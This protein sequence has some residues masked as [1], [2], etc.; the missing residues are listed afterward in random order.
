M[1]THLA[2]W[3]K[4]T[5]DGIEAESILRACVH[6][7]FCN[8]TCPTYQLLGDELDGPRGRIY[9]IKQV[10][11]GH[12]PGE[13]TQLHLDRCL[14]CMNCET[15]CPSGVRYGRLVDI[16]RT[17]VE[18]RVRRPAGKRWQR[19]LLRTAL[20]TRWLFTSAVRLGR[21]VRP[22]LPSVLRNKLPLARTAGVVPRRS[23]A[24][25]VLLLNGCV[26]PA[27]MPAIDAA[28][29]RVL[30]ALG[31]E[32]IVAERS[33]CCGAIDYHLAALAAAQTSAR[34]NI[35]AWWPHIERGAEAIV[36]N[37][38]G[39]GAMV[40]EYAH[41]LRDDPVYAGKAGRVVSLTLDL[42]EFLAPMQQALA[43][44]GSGA[45][46][47]IAAPG[48]VAFHPPCTLQH[49]QKIRGTVEAILTALG[50]EL[51]PVADAHL[52][53][54]SAGSYSL[55]QS[56]L[57]LQLR[58]LKLENLQRER[59]AM[60]LSAN[61]GCIAHLDSG[62]EVPVRHWIEWVDRRLDQAEIG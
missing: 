4:S 52:C 22:L 50:A 44:K 17:I 2:D 8:A 48:R 12:R 41:V 45:V 36:I 53:C 11:E 47:A 5:A 20:T 10:L 26:Q 35:D 42:A 3:I 29:I 49:T 21:L 24:R 46:A 62:A 38:S 23:Q 7:G 39:C 30:D 15:T 40:K 18:Q 9:Q 60:I 56:D 13:S 1:E 14:T 51:V 55:L 33:G 6:C 31:I 32:A 61:I 34:R 19:A 37:A 57:S 54:G 28:T 16:G 43:A 27:L 58:T 59:P 25:K